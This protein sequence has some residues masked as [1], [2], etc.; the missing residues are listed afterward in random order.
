MTKENFL[1]QL[2]LELLFY[3]SVE[4]RKSVIEDYSEYFE[5]ALDEG[6]SEDEICKQLGDAK[7][8]AKEIIGNGDSRNSLWFG[9]LDHKMNC[10]FK[11]ANFARAITLL[12][13]IIGLAF[14]IKNRGWIFWRYLWIWGDMNVDKLSKVGDEV[15]YLGPA[16]V[17][18]IM[19]LLF[20]FISLGSA[21][22]IW[23]SR[24][25]SLSRLFQ[26]PFYVGSCITLSNI[27]G[28]LR[29]FAEPPLSPHLLRAMIPF[30]LWDFYFCH[31]VFCVD[32]F[33][34][35]RCKKW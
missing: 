11:N 5:S 23:S 3:L 35:L 32:L 27:N 6:T 8:L 19:L 13:L 31:F 1:Y 30:F 29:S 17:G 7:R 22:I 9:D 2:E 26:M 34:K 15:S 10:A 14:W 25:S 12:P 21:C 20:V 18:N 4:D 16:A 33:Q 24:K 28:F